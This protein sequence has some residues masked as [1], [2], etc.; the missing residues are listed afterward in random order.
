MTLKLKV[1]DKIPEISRSGRTTPELLMI[2]EAL[3]NSVKLN[4]SFRL[5][6]IE[7]G[8]P[9]NSMQQRIRAQSKKLGYKI[10][11]RYDSSEKTL[12]FK[13]TKLNTSVSV[14]EIPSVAVKNSSKK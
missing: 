5:D 10:A 6:G 14:K 3:N 1:V 7:P 13:A 11:I 9:F 2:I 4:Q 12:F 8:N